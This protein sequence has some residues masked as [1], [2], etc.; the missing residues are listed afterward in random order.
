LYSFV[1]PQHLSWRRCGVASGC[2]RTRKPV[3]RK[4]YS[5]ARERFAQPRR[6]RGARGRS[7]ACLHGS[8]RAMSEAGGA[9]SRPSFLF[10]FSSSSAADE[11]GA[12]SVGQILLSGFE[13]G[14]GGRVFPSCTACR[15]LR[16]PQ[17][18]FC[19]HVSPSAAW[20]CPCWS[21]REVDSPSR[22]GFVCVR[23][24]M[25]SLTNDLHSQVISLACPPRKTLAW[26]FNARS[27]PLLARIPRPPPPRA[28]RNRFVLQL[29]RAVRYSGLV[30]AGA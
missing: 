13:A 3:I 12:D 8:L 29:L 4:I 20:E 23:V 19:I 28:N 7:S 26:P 2:L 22:D 9:A 25:D 27:R 15:A 21:R 11:H 10:F 14:G 16:V 1:C 24:Q 17:A 5:R 18:L 6:P 30:V